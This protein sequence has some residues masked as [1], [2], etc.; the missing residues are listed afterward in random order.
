MEFAIL[1][2][3]YPAEYCQLVMQFRRNVPQGVTERAKHDI[4]IFSVVKDSS[5]GF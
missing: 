4:N 5:S 1:N 3:A 2:D